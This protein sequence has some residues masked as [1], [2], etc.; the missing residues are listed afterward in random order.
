MT[1]TMKRVAVGFAALAAAGVIGG[2]TAVSLL[3]QQQPT[4]NVRTVSDE[5]STTPTVEVSAPAAA[6]SPRPTS[7]EGAVAATGKPTPQAPAATKTTAKSRSTVTDPGPAE[8]VPTEAQT[9]PR[10]TTPPPPPPFE[11]L[12]QEIGINPRCPSPPA[13]G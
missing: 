7:T 9:P 12:P 11:C 6:A 2:V 5:A 3:G 13:G 1:Q 4:Q 10:A 8:P